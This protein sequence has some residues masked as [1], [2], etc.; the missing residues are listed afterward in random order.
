MAVSVSCVA[1]VLS[2]TVEQFP[3]EIR[4]FSD[5]ILL[6][7]FRQSI[8]FQHGSDW[9]IC[10]CACGACAGVCMCVCDKQ[11]IEHTCV[12]YIRNVSVS[13]VYIISFGCKCCYY[14]NNCKVL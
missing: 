6:Y 14:V 7:R 3:K 11:V 10:V 1:K 12:N 2:N 13:L 4:F 5:S 9:Y 8:F